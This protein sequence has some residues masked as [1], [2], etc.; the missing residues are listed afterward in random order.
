MNTQAQTRQTSPIAHR[1]LSPLL[2][3]FSPAHSGAR[4]PSLR[5]LSRLNDGVSYEK[6][7]CGRLLFALR[8][9]RPEWTAD[10]RQ[11][12]PS[13]HET[14]PVKKI[15][16]Y[17]SREHPPWNTQPSES[18]DFRCSNVVCKFCRRDVACHGRYDGIYNAHTALFEIH[19][20][21]Q[22]QGVVR[23]LTTSYL[24]IES[25]PWI[26]NGLFVFLKKLPVEFRSTA[27]I[28]QATCVITKLFQVPLTNIQCLCLHNDDSYANLCTVANSPRRW[29]HAGVCI[30]FQG[31]LFNFLAKNLKKKNVK[32]F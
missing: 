15:K 4:Y 32:I 5:L 28:S 11:F 18:T 26:T 23:V 7:H 10:T 19:T 24:S 29:L 20:R 14:S 27:G 3:S 1:P 6:I 31:K 16:G 25:T 9:P 21:K 2:F 30:C 22:R 17:L 8:L 12:S 13:S